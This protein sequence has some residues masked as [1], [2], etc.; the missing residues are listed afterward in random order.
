MQKLADA[1][2]YSQSAPSD[3]VSRL[4]ATDRFKLACQGYSVEKLA[5]ATAE[6]LLAQHWKPPITCIRFR[7]KFRAIIDCARV[8]HGIEWEHGDFSGYL[9]TFGV[10]PF[11]RSHD[12]IEVFWVGFDRL[13][14]DLQDKRMPY[15]GKTT[16]LLQL[17]LDLG[18]DS[19]KPDVIVMRIAHRWRIVSREKGD[20]AFR[21]AVRKMQ[22]YAV[23]RERR[24]LA[25]DWV[26]LTVGEQREALAKW[27]GNL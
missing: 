5:A 9:G 3:A 14:K 6:K 2:A 23:I 7:R 1:I 24:A 26:V 17:L 18:Y 12:D 11:L 21:Q 13:Q 19:I 16:S 10:P 8:L 4:L 20:P 22:E 27:R 15:F 25:V